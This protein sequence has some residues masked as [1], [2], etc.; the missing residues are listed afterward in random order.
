MPALLPAHA[1]ARLLAHV[2][3]EGVIVQPEAHEPMQI[4]EPNHPYYLRK[5]NIQSLGPDPVLAKRLR[6]ACVDYTAGW[7]QRHG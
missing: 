3:M 4:A 1:P 2:P 5:R 6:F 7:K